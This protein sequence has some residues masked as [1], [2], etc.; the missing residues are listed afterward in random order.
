MRVVHGG[1]NVERLL[2]DGEGGGGQNVERLLGDGEGAVVDNLDGV[3][4][5]V[6]EVV[7]SKGRGRW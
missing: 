3:Q 5:A 2:G 7:V 4:W 6:R 1:Q